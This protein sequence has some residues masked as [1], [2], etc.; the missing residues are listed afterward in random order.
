MTVSAKTGKLDYADD[1]DSASPLHVLLFKNTSPGTSVVQENTA[2][3][4]CCE[5]LN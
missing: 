1:A 5:S 2:T 3:L 4:F